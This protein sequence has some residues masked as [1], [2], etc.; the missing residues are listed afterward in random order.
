VIHVT[1]ASTPTMHLTA[2][3]IAYAAACFRVTLVGVL[4]PDQGGTFRIH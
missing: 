1:A 3:A 2:A 4:F